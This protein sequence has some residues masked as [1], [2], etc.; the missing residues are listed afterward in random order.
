MCD[1][2]RHLYIFLDEAGNLDFSPKGTKYFQLA[3]LTKER[4]FHAYKELTELKYDLVELGT[5]LEYFH[6]S[7]NAQPVRNRVFDIIRR[8]LEGVRIDVLVVEKR[9]TGPALQPVE[10]FYPQMLGY[11]LRYILEQHDLQRFREVIVITDALPLKKKKAA[12]EKAI[13]QTLA[14]MLPANARYRVL[15]HE[16][17][18]NLD[19][20]IADY[21]NWALFRKWK[22]GDLRSYNVIAPAVRSEFDIFRTGTTLYY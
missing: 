20:Q 14:K 21:C 19:L 13:R 9:K 10:R 4:P 2:T 7:E 17:K 11:L 18:S 5:N 12:I 22:D 8:N 16:S 6:A 1:P 3:A 15:H